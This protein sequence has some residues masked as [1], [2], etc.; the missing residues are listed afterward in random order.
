MRV[1][2]NSLL[3]EKNTGYSHIIG[4]VAPEVLRT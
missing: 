1:F 4:S 3:Q 2:F